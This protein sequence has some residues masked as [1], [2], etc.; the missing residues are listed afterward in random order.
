[1]NYI[2]SDGVV[3]NNMTV[4]IEGKTIPFPKDVT[5]NNVTISDKEVFVDGHEL[6]DGEW[7]KT[8]KGLWNR[9]F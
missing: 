3:V 9:Y 1:M 2:Q 7:K 5:G 8:L 6:I 4:L